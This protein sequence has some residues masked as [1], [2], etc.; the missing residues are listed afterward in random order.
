MF[1]KCRNSKQQG[2]FGLSSAINYFCHQGYTVSIPLT[3]S[4]PYDLIIDKEKLFRVQVKTTSSKRDEK[5]FVVNLRT[6]GG[7]QKKFWCRNMDKSSVDILFV[8]TSEGVRYNI[9]ISDIKANN[10]ICLRSSYDKY[11]IL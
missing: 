6:M 3:D 8:L 9:P 10:S 11:K 1:E 4:Q 7:N 2:D 5:H